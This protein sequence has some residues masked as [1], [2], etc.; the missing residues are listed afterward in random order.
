M[1]DEWG[2]LTFC[3]LRHEL[4]LPAHLRQLLFFFFV[5]LSFD[6]F[7]LV[8]FSLLSNAFRVLDELLSLFLLDLLRRWLW[9]HWLCG[10]WW[11]W[12]VVWELLL[13]VGLSQLGILIDFFQLQERL[14]LWWNKCIGALLN[15]VVVLTLHS[16]VKS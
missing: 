9:W 6:D 14:L 11:L 4:L 7:L 5:D 2:K 16:N 3:I 13:K 15:D 12:I 10:C 8:A 1:F